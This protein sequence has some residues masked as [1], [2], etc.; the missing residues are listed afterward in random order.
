MTDQVKARVFEPFFSTKDGTK[1]TG[2]GLAMVYGTVTQSGGAIHVRSTPGQGSTFD[3]YFPRAGGVPDRDA[4]RPA[5]APL[6]RGGRETLLLVED[7]DPVR[8]LA[9]RALRRL[10]YQVLEARDGSAALELC[11]AHATPVDL[12]VS[13]VVMPRMGG[14]ELATRIRDR[15]PGVPVV[16]VSGYTEDAL[17][18]AA[19]L[20]IDADYVQKPF[21]LAVLGEAVRRALDARVALGAGG[22]G[23]R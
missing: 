3:L 17:T 10:G 23:A 13:D 6:V 22:P 12:L 19:A 1:G 9:A 20:G 8:N 21:R 15:W 11:A 2:L 14:V 7:E 18:R 4:A 16:F 5:A